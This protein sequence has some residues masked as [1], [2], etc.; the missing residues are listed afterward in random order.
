MIQIEEVRELNDGMPSSKLE[1]YGFVR[2]EALCSVWAEKVKTETIRWPSTWI[3]AIK[4]RWAPAWVKRRWPVQ[5][6]GRAVTVWRA[7]DVRRETPRDAAKME[8]RLEPDYRNFD[9][10]TAPI[11]TVVLEKRRLFVG[12]QVSKYALDDS[13]GIHALIE[14]QA[15]GKLNGAQAIEYPATWIDVVW[16]RW[17]PAHA[18]TIRRLLAFTDEETGNRFAKTQLFVEVERLPDKI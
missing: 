10:A 9:V 17:R 14:R 1:E 15:A 6:D 5:W 16:Q 18:K 12:V 2:L 7:Y 3:E 13:R 8:I 11:Q 4:D